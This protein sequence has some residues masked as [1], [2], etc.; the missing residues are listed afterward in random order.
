M[1]VEP[2]PAETIIYISDV[3]PAFSTWSQP[4]QH[5]EIIVTLTETSKASSPST[6]A[7]LKTTSQSI[8]NS[9]SDSQVSTGSVQSTRPSASQ[10][11]SVSSQRTQDSMSRS[12]FTLSTVPRVST[13]STQNTR[14][15]SPSSN[16]ETTSHPSGNPTV[17]S[18]ERP[19]LSITQPS[20][21][22]TENPHG[23]TRPPTDIPL[24]E[25]TAWSTMTSYETSAIPTHMVNT[26]ECPEMA[27]SFP[28]PSRLYHLRHYRRSLQVDVRLRRQ[29]LRAPILCVKASKGI[30]RSRWWWN[31]HART[32]PA[33]R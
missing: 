6:R 26:D 16:Q 24:S 33:R 7:L 18:S 4:T 2:Q 31:A 11:S 25:S 3:E 13:G 9:T 14:S 23:I 21:S 10:S 17:S 19:I 32:K 15:F 22:R 8:S 5:S 20:S 30:A 1:G 28:F 29:N 27:T 12:G